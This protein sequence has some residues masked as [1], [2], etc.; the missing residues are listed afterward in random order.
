MESIT[1]AAPACLA[2]TVTLPGSKSITNR[3]LLVAALAP[4]VSRISGAL[5]SDD[6]RYMA[7]ALGQLGV[8]IEEPDATTFV[9]HG[10]GGHFVESATPLFLGNAGTAV[11]FLA[12]LA[13]LII[14]KTVVTGDE[15]MQHRPIGDL[16]AALSQLGA[17]VSLDSGCPPLTV[18]STGRLTGRRVTV[19]GDISSQFVSALLMVLPYAAEETEIVLEGPLTSPGYTQITTSVMAAFGVTAFA[20]ATGWR[21]P[22]KKYQPTDFGVEPDASSATYFW[23]IEKLCDTTF[24]FPGAPRAWSQPDADSRTILEKFP[25]PFGVVD[26]TNFP[27][28]VPTLA[29]VA[30]FADGYTRFTGIRNLRVKECDRIAALATELNKLADGLAHEDGDELVIHGRRD[31]AETAR[32]GVLIA[33]YH[34]H[35]IALAFSLA[36]LRIS[37]LAIQ[38]PACVS[39][40]FPEFWEVLQNLGVKIA[41][42]NEL[43]TG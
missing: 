10:R 12:A 7:A 17:Q 37:G 14:G 31:L 2:G 15:R 3:A 38:N 9:V 20:T 33:T 41:P 26:A 13:P 8:K 27:D 4:G 36:A 19:R 5:K 39:K 23:G 21:V 25:A 32:R 16:A 18:V 34:D 30:A 29:V 40:S 35:R 1:L 6:T 11:R 43:P 22:I 28:A 42:Q 24:E